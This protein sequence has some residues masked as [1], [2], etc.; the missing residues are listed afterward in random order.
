MHLRS[1]FM[2]IVVLCGLAPVSG[3]GQQRT[4]VLDDLH[5]RVAPYS[6]RTATDVIPSLTLRHPN[7]AP[8]ADTLIPLDGLMFTVDGV[9]RNGLTAT[10]TVHRWKQVATLSRPTSGVVRPSAEVRV[11][12]TLAG[13]PRAG[14]NVFPWKVDGLALYVADSATV[15]VSWTSTDLPQAVVAQEPS[16]YDPT[17]PIIKFTTQRD[18]VGA[19]AASA[20][21]SIDT[22]FNGVSLSELQLIWNR[23]EQPIGVIDTDGTGTFTSSDTLLFIARHPQGDT[24]WLDLDDTVATMYLTRATEGVR[25]RLEPFTQ[26]TASNE[27]ITLDI[28]R[29]IELDTGYYSLGYAANA[30]YGEYYTDIAPYEGFYWDALNANSYERVTY[31]FPLGI[32]PNST[33]TITAHYN[34]TTNAV[35]LAPDTRS[36][37][38]L[39]GSNSTYKESDGPG[40]FA[41]PIEL[42]L[43]SSGW[44][45][46]QSVKLFSTGNDTLRDKPGYFSEILLDWINVR[47]TILPVLDN[48]ELIANSQ[49][50][51]TNHKLEL[52]NARSDHGYWID[53]VHRTWGRMWNEFP[54]TER[55]TT[56][57]GGLSLRDR[58]W[59]RTPVN[60]DT[61]RLSTAFNDQVVEIE[62]L[63]GIAMIT[64]SQTIIGRSGT[65]MEEVASAIRAL[66][67]GDA[68]VLA[69]SKVSTPSSVSSA[70][71]D[72]LGKE[73]P[74]GYWV[75]S[76]TKQFDI[77]IASSDTD[78]LV[79]TTVTSRNDADDR[80]ILTTVLPASTESSTLMISDG[81]SA[82]HVVPARPKL[83]I[84]FQSLA[85]ADLVIV[86]HEIHRQQAERLAQHRRDF[87]SI[88]V[89]VVDVDS[90]L[91]DFGNGHHS[92]EA[93]RQYLAWYYTTAPSP[94]ITHIILFGNATWDPR[95]AV[96]NGNVGARR[97][98]Q[99]PT[100]G[101]PSSDYYLGLLDDPND[102]LVPEAIVGRI[103]ALTEAEGK[104]IVDKIII[105]DTS[106]YEPWM[107]RWMYVGGGTEPEGLCDIYREVTEDPYNTGFKVSEVPLC[108]DTTTLCRYQAPANA[109][110]YLKQNVNNGLQWLNYI[111]HGATDV[112]DITGWE[113]NELTNTGRY[114]VLA[115]FACQTGA[116]SN[117]S[118]PCKNAQYLTEPDRGFVG[119]LG[120]TGWA[121]TGTISFLHYIMH[122][123]MNVH[124]ARDL[125]KI[126][127]DSK[128]QVAAQF[129]QDGINTAMQ[130]SILGDPLMRI[131]LDTV[132]DALVNVREV[133]IATPDGDKQIT[134]DDEKAIVSVRVLNR[135]VGTTQPLTIKMRHT[136]EGVS[137]SSEVVL[138][139]GL[140]RDG[141]ASFTI[142]TKD[143]A[144]QHIVTIVVDPYN[145][146]GD[147]RSNNSITTTFSVLPRS[148]LPL[149]PVPHGIITRQGAHVRVIDPISTVDRP[150]IIEFAYTTST[151][152]DDT[153]IIVRSSADDV[154]QTKS[155]VDWDVSLAP[156]V[157]AGPLWV[158]AWAKDPQTGQTSAVLWVPVTLVE[159]GMT[160]TATISGSRLAT[161]LNENMMFDEDRG[162]VKL[163]RITRD[164]FLRSS[165]INTANLFE[166]PILEMNIG[167][168]TWVRNPYFRGINL[169]VIGQNDTIPRAIRR[170]DT[171]R[172]PLPPE[173]G[174][175]GSTH[176]CIRFLRDSVSASER[177]MFAVCNEAFTGFIEDGN[178][179]T[180]REI[181]KSYGSSYAD[182]LTEASSWVMFGWPGRDPMT[183]E[184]A[185]KGYPDSMVTITVP[186]EFVSSSGTV[187]GTMI[188]PSRTW[189]GVTL[190]HADSGVRAT[191][192]GRDVQGNVVYLAEL[193]EGEKTWTPTDGAPSILFLQANWSVFS[194]GSDTAA[195]Y[196]R[197]MSASFTPAYEVLIEPQDISIAPEQVLRGD[198]TTVSFLIRNAD[199]RAEIASVP[200]YVSL[201]DTSGTVR[202]MQIVTVAALAP[203][204]ERTLMVPMAS[205]AATTQS[206]IVVAADPERSRSQF[207]TF[208]DLRT[209]VL[210]VSEDAAPPQITAYADDLNVTA[211][212]YVVREPLLT[213][214]LHDNS[215]LP[216]NDPS[217]LVVF[218]NGQRI[219]EGT[220]DDFEFLTTEA[221]RQRYSDTT[222]RS[223]MVF[224]YL[225]D[226]GQNN[227][228]VR[229]SDATGNPAELESELWVTSS[230]T[231]TGVRPS[232]NPTTG[233]T[234][235]RISLQTSQPTS[236]ASIAIYDTEGRL[237]RRLS[238]TLQLGSATIAW[239]GRGDDGTS[240]SNGIYAYRLEV[241][242]PETQASAATSGTLVILR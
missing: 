217:R 86:T 169:V 138:N 20:V 158:A 195:S 149:E 67:P 237:V 152:L 147:D 108:F 184:E 183:A 70:I 231:I 142:L 207:Y 6:Q 223:A 182:S 51:T 77:K 132:V 179:D 64:P 208:N 112:F 26:R 160:D 225:L 18:G 60:T 90:V 36:D 118:V 43:G 85:Q 100:Y 136:Y 34:T 216:I 47:A 211:G 22:R 91:E 37:L 146:L 215:K 137:D 31:R 150:Q 81:A 30:D 13:I 191:L 141:I 205:N 109:G 56:I 154:R 115:T 121:R 209:G 65:S 203:D 126:T 4:F 230:T 14:V 75:M 54:S 93:L 148:L 193:G 212:G 221:C 25:S 92:V 144:G 145:T 164:I 46:I 73:V 16:W 79:G 159:G 167:D 28:N 198:T 242:N 10:L 52:S 194:V 241:D 214:F 94:A 80:Y 151:S 120:G 157:P 50:L 42:Q 165:A 219:R 19:V 17:Q 102:R 76:G 103:P 104:S 238:A 175:N 222:L 2:T 172:D 123:E 236:P 35:G 7:V 229:A 99:V 153:A 87:N 197:G 9:Q 199:R 143:K 8:T 190:D 12:G 110:Y 200:V 48:G 116:Y 156:S 11:L 32:A 59:I 170:Y 68:F 84:R 119:A 232:P 176:E 171:W 39:N 240:L 130:Y 29:H 135:G 38:T 161:A 201:I 98:D 61:L 192:Y 23:S 106:A 5:Q 127:Y 122:Q 44:A 71:R 133:V 69:N 226:D 174:N 202:D 180:L 166:E 125:G 204:E 66:K 63:Y 124:D 196:V 213:V 162:V 101:R 96:K 181:L 189:H 235:F 177:V 3:A 239:D 27:I 114:G 117:P 228:I 1:L 97:P 55:Y 21:L 88:N 107:R 173:T 105:N 186:T 49:P 129:Q 210:S 206:A 40:S 72:A 111:G 74:S 220:A 53:T 233:E 188:G 45:G 139:D 178:L 134:D 57:R 15:S 41:L 82:Q 95:L 224:R 227:L 234:V 218:V 78:P 187:V 163:N 140:C 58:V 33:A 128:L 89:H 24:T 168:V 155:V 83:G 62:D 113:P 185:W 131:H